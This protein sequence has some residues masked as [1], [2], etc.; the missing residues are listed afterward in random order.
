MHVVEPA[1][2]KPKFNL[3]F[4]IWTAVLVVAVLV[5]AFNSFATVQ[6]GNV[7]LYKTFGKLNII[8]CCPAFI[9]K[10]RSFRRS[11]K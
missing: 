6:Y 9:S 3:R 11:F 10:Y 8:C 2:G 7:G 4:I 1:T 5:I